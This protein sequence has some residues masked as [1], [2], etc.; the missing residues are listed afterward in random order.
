MPKKK[1]RYKVT[2]T[3]M[4][5]VV[6]NRPPH[7]FTTS[8]LIRVF[9]RVIDRDA[10]ENYLEWLVELLDQLFQIALET[11]IRLFAETWS[12][13]L[14]ELIIKFL[15]RIMRTLAALGVAAYQFL[16]AALSKAFGLQV[17][18]KSQ[19]VQNE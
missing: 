3:K 11:F 10:D 2:V 13:I 4:G 7:E 19:E 12:L 8:D 17:I 14:P 15:E 16:L 9:K 5:R 1:K 6:Y 18:E